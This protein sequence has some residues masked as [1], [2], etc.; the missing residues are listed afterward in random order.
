MAQK[1]LNKCFPFVVSY[2]ILMLAAY[3]IGATGIVL[4]YINHD[5]S[6]IPSTTI[7]YDLIGWWWMASASI[8]CG[9]VAALNLFTSRNL[10]DLSSV[11]ISSKKIRKIAAMN[12][13]AALWCFLIK[14]VGV[15]LPLEAIVSAAGSCTVLAIVGKKASESVI[16]TA[17]HLIER[18]S[19]EL[20]RKIEERKMSGQFIDSDNDGSDDKIRELEKKL[21]IRTSQLM[22][23]MNKN[24]VVQKPKGS[25]IPI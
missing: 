12:Y 3:S 5:W 9:G 4:P 7:P 10:K 2:Y 20:K 18:E 22:K 8:Y 14:M 15:D 16:Q 6:F 23:E 25:S 17:K 13:F 24:K 19:E 21:S 1:I 11:N